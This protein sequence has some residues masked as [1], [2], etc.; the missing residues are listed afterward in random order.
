MIYGVRETNIVIELR[1]LLR[2]SMLAGQCTVVNIAGQL[3][4]HER[5][6]HRRLREHGTSF[7]REFED[8]R[9]EAAWERGSGSI[10]GLAVDAPH[11][12]S[13]VNEPRKVSSGDGVPVAI[14]GNTMKNT[15]FRICC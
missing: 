13:S 4:L 7:R 1:S 9:Y 5:S 8:V 11:S 6:L 3:C 15:M 10:P 14:R 2:K 12:H